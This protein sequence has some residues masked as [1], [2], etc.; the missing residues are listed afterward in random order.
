LVAETNRLLPEALSTP[1]EQRLPLVELTFP[2]MQL[3]TQKQRNE[4]QRDVDLLIKADAK[5]S[6]F[7]FTVQRTLMRRLLDAPY[8]T[9]VR[10][11]AATAQAAARILLGALSYAGEPEKAAFAFKI[12]ADRLHLIGELPEK[13]A[14]GLAEVDQALGVLV[15]TPMSFKKH[16]LDAC[17]A[18]AG[19]DGKISVR[20]AELFRAIGD[21]LDCPVAPLLA[22]EI[23][24]S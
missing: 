11:D 23:A 18:I 2:A 14:C 1:P 6:L 21:S 10:P 9:K 19:A 7:E 4:F 24:V 13:S 20:E 3:M 15:S 5:I 22:N 12:G 8:R 16:L 17:S